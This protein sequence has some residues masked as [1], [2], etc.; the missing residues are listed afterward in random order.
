MSGG[1]AAPRHELPELGLS[2]ALHPDWPVVSM[3]PFGSEGFYQPVAD[4]G[5][6]VFVRHGESETL[7]CYLGQLGGMG[8]EVVVLRDEQTTVSGMR[9]RRVTV[10]L[11]TR[12]R[13]VYRSTPKGMEHATLPTEPVTLCVTGF[14]HRGT[15][16]LIG[17]RLPA[18]DAGR[19]TAAVEAIID[20][21]SFPSE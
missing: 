8:T 16:I 17:Y 5:G 11:T 3:A 1:D 14:T 2:I 15:P 19:H 4:T 20:S 18:K 10:Q 12:A 6:I 21:A 7:D 13:D 9:A